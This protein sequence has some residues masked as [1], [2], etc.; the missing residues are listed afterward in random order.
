MD[1]SGV[2]K[3]GPDVA[4]MTF[5]VD[6]FGKSFLNDFLH[7]ANKVPDLENCPLAF[8]SP[9]KSKDLFYQVGTA[10]GVFLDHLQPSLGFWVR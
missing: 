10:L 1:L 6:G 4:G 8:V 5:E 2:A 9:G 3:N 7:L